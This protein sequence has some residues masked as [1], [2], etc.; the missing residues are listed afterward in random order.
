MSCVQRK[1]ADKYDQETLLQ[2]STSVHTEQKEAL[3]QCLINK[4]SDEAH[5][6]LVKPCNIGCAK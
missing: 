2:V 3:S 6:V 5:L 4:E 1:R